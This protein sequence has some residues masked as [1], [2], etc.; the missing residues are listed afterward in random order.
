[1]GD[2]WRP[3]DEVGSIVSHPRARE[4]PGTALLA[5]MCVTDAVVNG[6]TTTYN[7][8]RITV[9]V[10]WWGW[11][12]RSQMHYYSASTLISKTVVQ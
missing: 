2:I 4:L 6:S 9:T 10:Q 5:I 12:S 11:G 8:I 1:M 3:H 7:L